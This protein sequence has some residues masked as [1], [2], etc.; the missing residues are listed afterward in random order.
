M[1]PPKTQSPA[2]RTGRVATTGET[3]MERR[4]FILSL[5][6]AL[7]LGLSAARAQGAGE[8]VASPTAGTLNDADQRR[9]RAYVRARNYPLVDYGR[10]IVIGEVLPESGVT[11]YE[12]PAEYNV[13]NYRYAYL[14]NRILIV[15][16]ASRR[17]VQIIE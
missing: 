14:S 15:D 10:P 11:Y 13:P 17:I 2:L 3:M 9:F 16:P 7:A 4:C 5:P 8:G 6:A 12:I 1:F